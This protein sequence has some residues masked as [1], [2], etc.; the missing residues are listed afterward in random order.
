MKVLIYQKEN[1]HTEIIGFFLS[2]YKN[3][4]I[5]F[6]HK[7]R[8]SAFNWTGTYKQ[9]KV[10]YVTE[11][12]RF[13]FNSYDRIIFLTSRDII[14][15]LDYLKG[16]DPKKV[17]QIR[18]TPTDKYSPD[19]PNVSLSPLVKADHGHFLTIAD[20]CFRTTKN[21][22]FDELHFAVLGISGYSAPKKDI[23]DLKDFSKSLT[24]NGISAKIHIIS[25]KGPYSQEL[26][27]L[28]NVEMHYSLSSHDTYK[29]LEGVHFLLPI[30]KKK[31][32]YYKD[33]MTG[34]IPMSYS[35]GIPMLAPKNFL[36][37]YEVTTHYEYINS[38][39]EI[40]PRL[41]KITRENYLEF[42][43]FLNIEKGRLT[44]KGN[45]LIKSIT[46]GTIQM[47][48]SAKALKGWF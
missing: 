28:P 17:L 44:E 6:C 43:G 10:R 3:E 23:E 12:T 4:E 47:G 36:D 45:T 16:I 24:D 19:Y 1:L 14:E 25:K 48:T 39:T 30:P 8:N 29:L 46:N 5:H 31:G 40:I 33:R 27:K 11:E 20:D 9:D 38:L 13:S 7:Y 21:L 42:L 34:I 15:N 18:H 41:Q 2:L 35:F 32:A 22:Q 37:I 26:E